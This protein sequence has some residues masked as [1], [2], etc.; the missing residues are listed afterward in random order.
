MECPTSNEHKGK[1]E[2]M[3][4]TRGTVNDPGTNM[5]R[6]S[7][8]NQE[9][10]GSSN[11]A[12]R[13]R[14]DIMATTNSSHISLRELIVLI[15]LAAVAMA[16]LRLSLTAAVSFLLSGI[17]ISV[18]AV[19]APFPTRWAFAVGFV[20][21]IGTYAGFLVFLPD[22]EPSAWDPIGHLLWCPLFGYFGGRYAAIVCRRQR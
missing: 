20:L 11:N 14:T 15:S 3:S 8:W 9:A 10:A 21:C 17:V 6:Y 1:E 16:S 19:I 18:L 5:I 7:R 4:S 12:I 22:P 13:P 2:E